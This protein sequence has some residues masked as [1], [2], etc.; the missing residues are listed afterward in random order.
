MSDFDREVQEL[1]QDPSSWNPR[2]DRSSDAYEEVGPWG[3]GFAGRLAQ[4]L[5]QAIVDDA[6]PA[7]RF[8]AIRERIEQEGLDLPLDDIANKTL[9]AL[10][11]EHVQKIETTSELVRTSEYSSENF[12]KLRQWA[13]EAEWLL[14]ESDTMNRELR[15][16]ARDVSQWLRENVRRILR[17]QL[18]NQFVVQ[19]EEE[20]KQRLI[21]GNASNFH[22]AHPREPEVYQQVRRAR[23]SAR[24]QAHESPDNPTPTPGNTR[25]E[26]TV[27]TRRDDRPEALDEAQEESRRAVSGAGASFRPHGPAG[28]MLQEAYQKF[29]DLGTQELAEL[30][31]DFTEKLK[32]Q[33]PA[34]PARQRLEACIYALEGL[35]EA[36]RQTDVQQQELREQAREEFRH[37]TADE[38]EEKRK[39]L[40]QFVEKSPAR[41]RWRTFEQE[42]LEVL[43][44]FAETEE[45][46]KPHL[47]E[48]EKCL[49]TFADGDRFVCLHTD[50]RGLRQVEQEMPTIHEPIA[51]DQQGEEYV[52]DRGRW[53]EGEVVMEEIRHFPGRG[54]LRQKAAQ[55]RSRGFAFHPNCSPEEVLEKRRQTQAP[56]RGR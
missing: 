27:E 22:E 37:L 52:E 14:E 12:D 3:T 31:E 49:G 36:R 33:Q 6:V 38:R 34:G 35:L 42:R 20:I 4:K 13:Q 23:K 40:E 43:E 17:E 11:G 55:L 51:R 7:Q 39:E 45:A 8:K 32:K 9:S 26:S 50:G 44:E 18:G 2:Q 30:K 54:Q 25:S 15:G 29:G 24:A 10:W 16:V 19:L 56:G 5:G 21:M 53:D 46:E 1:I 28:P 48:L 47:L 41:G